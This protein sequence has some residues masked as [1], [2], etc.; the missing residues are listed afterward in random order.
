MTWVKYSEE[1]PQYG[2]SF[3]IRAVSFG[4]LGLGGQCWA[5]EFHSVMRSRVPTL[6]AMWVCCDLN[7]LVAD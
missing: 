4:I 3:S 6:Q 2:N 5:H 1:F 7:M